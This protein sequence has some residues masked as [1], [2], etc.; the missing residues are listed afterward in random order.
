[1]VLKEYCESEGNGVTLRFKKF[2]DTKVALYKEYFLE[3]YQL[4]SQLA[5]MQIKKLKYITATFPKEMHENIDADVSDMLTASEEM[6]LYLKELLRI[7]TQNMSNI[8]THSTDYNTYSKEEQQVF[9]HAYKLLKL[10]GKLCHTSLVI[11][12]GVLSTKYETQMV[13]LF[14]FVNEDDGDLICK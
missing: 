14:A 2:Y 10:T 7:S 1:M 5:N 13:K 3:N 11:G 4:F 8:L 12:E 6:M 9:T